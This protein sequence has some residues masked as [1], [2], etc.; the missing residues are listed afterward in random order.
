MATTWRRSASL[1]RVLLAQASPCWAITVTLA[2]RW[3]SISRSKHFRDRW[4]TWSYHWVPARRH[5][6][7]LI[8]DGIVYLLMAGQPTGIA[9]ISSSFIISHCL[10]ARCIHFD[11]DWLRQG[12]L[13]SR[14]RAD[15]WLAGCACRPVPDSPQPLLRCYFAAELVGL[16]VLMTG[17]F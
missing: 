3:A 5:F 8:P 16:W 15:P 12:R 17:A 2:V 7:S 13:H 4:M 14:L 11:L 6:S 10:E 1:V 9:A